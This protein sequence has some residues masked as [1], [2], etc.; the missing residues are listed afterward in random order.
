MAATIQ[1]TSVTNSPK[2]C[3]GTY[4]GRRDSVADVLNNVNASTPT[5]PYSLTWDSTYVIGL[6]KD[7]D[8]VLTFSADSASSNGQGFYIPEG[9]YA[10]VTS[11]SGT[12]YFISN[13]FLS[14]GDDQSTA[15]TNS[16]K[17]SAS[18]GTIVSGGYLLCSNTGSIA[19]KCFAYP[20]GGGSA[21]TL[22]KTRVIEVTLTPVSIKV[23]IIII[24]D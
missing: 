18:T 6:K 1:I 7:A 22:G 20:N 2:L 4:V 3:L 17:V 14:F 8:F 9:S 16:G 11:T 10:E 21:H 12:V 15:Y 23:K 13:K 19:L 5:T 24:N